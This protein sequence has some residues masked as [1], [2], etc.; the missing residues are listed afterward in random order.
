[1]AIKKQIADKKTTG[2]K[3]AAA[4]KIAE[5][6]TAQKKATA[7]KSVAKKAVAPKKV[8]VKKAAVK[9]S[10]ATPKN[11]HST[12]GKVDN[13]SVRMYCHGFGDCFLLTFL[14]GTTP[15]SRM[16]IDCGMLT[17]NSDTLAQAIADIKETCNSK[18]D[19]VVQTHEHK[20]HISGFNMK[21]KATKKLLW[22]DIEVTQAWLAW[23]ENTGKDG[24]T[25]AIQLK[26][27]Q[28]KK[29]QALA[30]ALGMYKDQIN[31]DNHRSMMLDE[32]RGSDYYDAQMR[33]AQALD[34]MLEFYDIQV[35]G[36][37]QAAD[38]MLGLT[39]KEAMQYFVSRNEKGGK[40]DIHFWNPGDLANKE[41]TGMEGVCFYFLGPPKDYDKLRVMDDSSHTEMY[42][43]N[44]GLSDNFFMALNEEKNGKKKK[45]NGTNGTDKEAE[46]TGAESP[47]N[48]KYFFCKDDLEEGVQHVYKTYHDAKNNWRSIETDWLHNAG[49]LALNLDSYT[50]NTSLVIAIEL[51]ESEKV[52]L[53]AADAQIGNWM[54]W[55]EAVS[56]K[57]PAPKL[58]WDVETAKGKKQVTATDLLERT[59]FYKVGHHASHNATAR[60]HGLELMTSKDLVAMVPVDEVVA[61]KQGK[62]GWEMP[63]PDLY[64]RLQQKAKGRI[65]RLDKG[66]LIKKSTDALAQDARPS[67][68]QRDEFNKCITES[69]TIITTDDG[70]KRPLYI[71]YLLKG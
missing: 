45:T 15:V 58:K 12:K 35:T 41:T 23:T 25:L 11:S 1:M 4:K 20:D 48:E 56:D 33:Y 64:K 31:S 62:K 34:Q 50:N 27:K 16:L 67:Q 42:M 44:M 53:F 7:K 21:D 9:K 70:T 8:A 17:G 13:V 66:N 43:N 38:Q 14:S 26:D 37:L 29:K 39:M 69:A 28:E 2:K 32:F 54:S 19:I 52:L 24:D 46:K 60:K 22:D 5:K 59:V 65:V 61:K 51:E 10:A 30:K 18:L 6:K 47:F 68:Q 57:N 49:V 55:T 36:G 71:E 63:A 3:Q 40:T